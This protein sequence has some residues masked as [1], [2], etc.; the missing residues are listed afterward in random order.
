MVY[1]VNFA[2][3]KNYIHCE[4]RNTRHG[5][6][7]VAE[8]FFN[9]KWYKVTVCYLNR[10][11]EYWRYQS[12]INSLYCT[13][14]DEYRNKAVEEWKKENNKKRI[15]KEEREKIY[16]EVDKTF[17]KAFEEIKENNQPEYNF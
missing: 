8:M 1:C 16:K 4:S 7:H 17:N 6:K 13:I 2:G 15:K 11:W 12:A 9:K 3:E 14:R 10:T 5:F